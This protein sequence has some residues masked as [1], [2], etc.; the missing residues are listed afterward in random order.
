MQSI[1][2]GSFL[3]FELSH[4][5][6]IWYEEYI[7]TFYCN[8]LNMAEQQGKQMLSGIISQMYQIPN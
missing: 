3:T 2:N 7:G 6:A 1:R 8:D 4:A 5:Q